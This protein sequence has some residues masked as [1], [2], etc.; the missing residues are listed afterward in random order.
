MRAEAG[1]HREAVS[2]WGLAGLV[3]GGLMAAV[4]LALG[5]GFTPWRFYNT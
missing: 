5:H 1:A 3:L 4:A 2:S